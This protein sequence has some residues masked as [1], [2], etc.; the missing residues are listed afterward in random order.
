[1]LYPESVDVDTLELLRQLQQEPLLE[2][3]R[4]VGGTALALQLGHRKSDDLGFFGHVPGEALELE[5]TLRAYGAV[6]L[7]RRSRMIQGYTVRGI[8][9]D[10]VEYP[11][12]WLD[13]PVVGDGLRLASYR[14]IAAMKLSAITNR[15]T[16]K[17]FVDLAFLL[18]QFPLSDMLD[19]YKRKYAD[20]SLFLVLKSLTYFDDADE[21]P[22]PYMLRPCDWDQAKQKIAD[23]VPAASLVP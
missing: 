4:L 2:E 17:D 19:F 7:G 14:D 5:Q 6:S 3:T 8:K 15:G 1:M 11:Y 10:F 12:P 21:D 9:V 18:D 20:A 22:M 16:K 13:D 23:A